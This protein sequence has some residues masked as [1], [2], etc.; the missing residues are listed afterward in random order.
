MPNRYTSYDVNTLNLEAFEN[1][2]IIRLKIPKHT[3]SFLSQAKSYA[4]YFFKVLAYTR[5]QKYDIVFSTS[6]RLFT[7]F[8]GSL[9]GFVK[10]SPHYLDLRDI[11]VDTVSDIFPKLSF[12]LLIPF[13]KLVES[14]TLSHSAKIN[15]IS[16]GFHKYFLERYPKANFHFTWHTN[17]IDEKFLKNECY[18]KKNI[19]QNDFVH[20]V[21]AGNIGEAQ[22]LDKIIPKL[23]D[24][25][26]SKIFF[27]V[28]GDGSGKH[29]LEE[30]CKSYTNIK[31]VNPINR[32]KLIEEYQKADVLFLHLK[33][34]NCFKKV[35][36]SKIFEYAAT[37]KPIWAGVDG[38]ASE[39]IESE[40]KN[41]SVFIPENLE[42]A[43]IAF[44]Q[45]NFSFTCRKTFVEEYSRNIIMKK[46][47]ND[48]ISLKRY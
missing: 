24:R 41:A 18:W 17:G 36:P 31:I 47:Y 29:L 32:N 15:L 40:I 9:I 37:G 8:L 23:L 4:F 2:K 25:L 3:G 43:F 38:Y 22:A 20:V 12:S 30:L 39:F 45:L 28:I 48:L 34:I 35:L 44:N 14:F 21:Y 16:R 13:L 26:G 46:M 1:V 10:G 11:F 27:N 19:K 7:G 6:S 42:D 5:K 33:G